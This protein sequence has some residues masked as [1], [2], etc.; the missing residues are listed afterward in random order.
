MNITLDGKALFD[1]Q[2]SQ[3][4][5]GSGSRAHIERAIHGLDGV[6]SIDLGERTREIR[7]K[8]ILRAPDRAAMQARTDSIAAF[9]DGGTHTLRTT[10]GQEYHH[11]RMDSFK[12][13]DERMSGSGL[14][15]EYEILYTQL[16]V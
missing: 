13:V 5:V 3:I 4:Q 1:E 2:G 9:I 16:G 7:Q 6:I 14:V 8:G 10:S 12:Q 11:I 15:V